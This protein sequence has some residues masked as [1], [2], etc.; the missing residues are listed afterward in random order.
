MKTF[1][2]LTSVVFLISCGQENTKT[3]QDTVR[4]D[5]AQ[6]VFARGGD[7]QELTE[8]WSASLNLR[9]A[10]IMRSFYA[11][12]V[13]YYGDRLTAEEVISRQEAYFVQNPDYK[14]KITEYIDE[15]QQPDGSWLIRIIKRVTS[16]GK[17][18][19]YPASVVFAKAEGGIW[20]IVAESDDITD[21]NKARAH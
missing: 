17:T 7:W 15:V 19:D 13:L 20:K 1:I 11:D 6:T 3:A 8:S 10:A 2:A 4:A 18:A 21:L 5:S 9:N 12:T 16:G 14:Q